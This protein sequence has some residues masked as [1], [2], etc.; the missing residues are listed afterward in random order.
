MDNVGHQSL[1]SFVFAPYLVSVDWCLLSTFSGLEFTGCEICHPE[2]VE[3]S[4][5]SSKTV[6]RKAIV[7]HTSSM[8]CTPITPGGDEMFPSAARCYLQRTR[9]R[10]CA[11]PSSHW[12]QRN[13]PVCCGMTLYTISVLQC[14]VTGEGKPRNF[15][16]ILGDLHHPHVIDRVK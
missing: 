4:L 6:L 15:P 3:K 13:G 16:F 9:R 14:I 11:F 8:L 2:G 12:Q 5:F 1:P 7:V 10:H